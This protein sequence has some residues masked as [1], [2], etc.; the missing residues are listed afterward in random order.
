[1]K[2]MIT[3]EKN[4]GRKYDVIVVGGGPAGMIAAGKA[5]EAGARVLLLE[6]NER[7]GKKLLL[8][9]NGRCNIAY[10]EFDNN[11]LVKSLGKKGKFLFSALNEFGLAK[12]MEFFSDL[13]VPVK[14]EKSGKVFPV[15]DKA[16]DVLQALEKYL[17]KNGVEVLMG[18]N[19]SGFEMEKNDNEKKIK[20]VISNGKTI[21]ADKFI[22][23][24][25]GK[26]YPVT[27]STGDGYTWARAFGH[28][29]IIPQPALVPLKIREDWTKELQGISLKDVKISLTQNNNK[30]IENQIGDLIFTHFGVSGPAILNLSRTLAE[31]EK[32]D[33]QFFL[34]ID[35]KPEMD[36][37]ELDA[38]MQEY[39][40]RNVN[41]N[42][43]NCLSEFVSQKLAKTILQL[44]GIPA[45]KKINI[46]T[47]EERLRIVNFIKEM[48]L[49]IAGNTGF[50]QA[51][52]TKGGVNLKE[53]DSKNMRSKIVDNLFL[54]GEVL[55]LDGPTGGYNLQIAWSTGYAAGIGCANS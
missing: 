47:K 28:T 23:A 12:V 31:L 16:P 30:K 8:T 55:D 20:G 19:V 40:A 5:G 34:S 38:V 52:V 41:K 48:R 37:K 21:C 42:I 51:M 6:K 17:K 45:E 35:L 1:M 4:N 53:I 50:E 3:T 18:A 24:T 46:I 49:T 15:S 32:S 44:T 2:K 27:G 39:F 36:K 14:I 54:A 33:D 9:G 7:L 10:A 13:G 22:L 29:I 25:G 26:S 11:E 43:N